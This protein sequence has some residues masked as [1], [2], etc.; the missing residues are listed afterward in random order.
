MKSSE[1]Y[2]RPTMM[3]AS[4]YSSSTGLAVMPSFTSKAGRTPDSRSRI[5]Q[6]RVRTVSLTQ[7]GMRQMMNSSEPARPRASFAMIQA[8]GNASSRV[9]NVAITDMTAVRRKTCQYRGSAKKVLYC[10]RLATY[11]RGP[12]RSRKDR[13]ARST[14]GNMIRAPSQSRAGASNRP[15]ARRP[16]QRVFIAVSRVLSRGSGTG[17]KTHGSGGI[18]TEC[19]FLLWFQVGKLPRLRQGYAKFAARWRFL[20]QDRRIR[21]VEQHALHFSRMV[22][23]LGRQACS[24]ARENR[25]FGTHEHLD[26]VALGNRTGLERTHD[27]TVG[28]R[29]FSERAV[30]LGRA[31][32][33][34][35]VR[36]HESRD[37][38]R[39]RPVVQ[40]LG[41]AQLF[42][43]SVTHH[44]DV[45]GQ[46]QGLGLIV[47][48]VNEGRA[49]GGLQLLELDFH[50]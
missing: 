36:A 23:L 25:D 42:E 46:H 38:R 15:S 24:A 28:G 16:C 4:R 43:T 29:N 40:V 50:V 47:G 39:L 1:V 2:T 12:T 10:A 35:V 8:T 20:E 37:E 17:R 22:W 31:A 11:W 30:R 7:N 27:P 41:S 13:M 21:S 18:E 33:D 5:I 48:D 45:I 6:P 9:R 44:A 14:C 26:G 32:H 19:H 34:P 3:V 49:E